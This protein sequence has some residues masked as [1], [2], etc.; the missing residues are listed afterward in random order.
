MV[1]SS[2]LTHRFQDVFLL[3]LCGCGRQWV[4]IGVLS[5][6]EH[7]FVYTPVHTLYY[8]AL[9][10]VWQVDGLRGVWY[11]FVYLLEELDSSGVFG[12]IWGRL[13]CS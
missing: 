4:L 3:W 11:W 8:G 1:V 6:P 5:P 2:C 12:G 9:S 7:E 13:D 10:G